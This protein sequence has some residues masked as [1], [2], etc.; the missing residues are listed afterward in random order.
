MGGLE[1]FVRNIGMYDY[2]TIKIE[3]A[4]VDAIVAGVLKETLEL[5][6][7]NEYD[8]ELIHALRKVLHHFMPR[9]DYEL[10]VQG[11]SLTELTRINEN[12]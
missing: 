3:D 2:K 11:L 7:D 6:I 9:R 8:E 10:Y 12:L 1:L 5:E 4:Q